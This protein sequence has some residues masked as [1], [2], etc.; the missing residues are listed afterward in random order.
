MMGDGGNVTVY[1]RPDRSRYALDRHG[2][3]CEC[4]ADAPT[5]GRPR[6]DSRAEASGEWEGS[7][8]IVVP[9]AVSRRARAHSSR[10]KRG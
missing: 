5:F 3:G 10:L 7:R 6:F 1:E 8:S 4:A 2:R 9:R